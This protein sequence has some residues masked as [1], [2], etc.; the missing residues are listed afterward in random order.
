MVLELPESITQLTVEL[1][2]S[3]PHAVVLLLAQLAS[4]HGAPFI[5]HMEGQPVVHPVT[6]PTGHG[7][8]EPPSVPTLLTV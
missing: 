4:Q 5:L 2:E 3:P 1:L 6:A 7:E 8:D